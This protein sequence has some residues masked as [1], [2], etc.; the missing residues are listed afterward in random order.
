MIK[1]TFLFPCLL[2]ILLFGACKKENRPDGM[3][4]LYPCKVKITLQDAPLEGASVN[5]ANATPWSG[6]G[7]TDQNGVVDIMTRGFPGAPEGEFKVLVTKNMITPAASEAAPEPK[8][9]ECV[10][11]KFAAIATSPLTCVVKP[12]KNEFEFKVEGP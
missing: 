7:T 2:S 11:S 5:L 12:E 4:V 9:E 3:P 10:H 1:Q 6:G 8:V